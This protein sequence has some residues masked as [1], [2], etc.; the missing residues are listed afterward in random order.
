YRK[1]RI[2]PHLDHAFHWLDGD[3]LGMFADDFASVMCDASAKPFEENIRSTAQFV[4]KVKGR[5][6]VEGAVDEIFEAGGEKEK[7]EPTRVEQ[8]EKLLSQTGVDIIVPN[9]GTEHRVTSGNVK[10]LSERARELSRALGKIL[11][12]HGTS[13]VGY[14]DLK[15]LPG[16]GFVKINIYTTLA[17]SGGQALSRTVLRN[18]KKIF[19]REQLKDFIEEGILSQH[20]LEQDIKLY[21]EI[22]PKI[23]YVCNPKR[24][25]A[26]FIAVRNRCMEFMEIFNYNRFADK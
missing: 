17:V 6:V 26:W 22:R 16:D 8:A 23:D 12:L 4:E 20:I 13:S 2:L 7:N 19:S 15:K 11:C 9:V 10:Y 1:L 3:V 5:V 21:G 25:D 14:E 18:L 24:R